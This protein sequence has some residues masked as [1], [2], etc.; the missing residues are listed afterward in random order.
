LRQKKNKL[1]YEEQRVSDIK[2]P[3]HW[4]KRDDQ[5]QLWDYMMRRLLLQLAELKKHGEIKTPGARAVEVAHRQWG[6][7]TLGM[8]FIACAAHLRVGNYWHMLPKSE[9][10]RTAIWTAIN[11]DTGILRIDE[12]F[13]LEIRKQTYQSEMKIILNCGSSYQLVGSDNYNNLV[14]SMPI[15]IWASEWALAN[16]LAWAYLDPMIEKNKGWI[17]FVS[18]SRGRNHLK[19]LYDFA[20]IDDDWFADMKKA[21]E[22]EVFAPEQLKKIERDTIGQFGSD[23]GK[24]IFLQEYECSFEGAVLGSYYSQQMAA[25]RAEK[26]ITVVPW[27]P[28]TEVNTYWDLGLDDSMTIWFIQHIGKSH[29]VIDYEEGTGLGLEWYAKKMKERPY[30]YGNNYMPHDADQREMTNS[31]IALS[32]REVAENLGIKPIIVIPRA[33]NMDVIVNVHIPAVRNILPS[34]WFDEKKCA[35]GINSLENYHAKYDEVKK[36]LT[37]R[38]EHDHNSHGADAFRTFA[39]GYEPAAVKDKSVTEMMRTVRI[40]N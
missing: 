1:G 5:T 29:H 15:G 16:P 4:S 12:A 9:Q 14:S 28:N 11:P 37:R 38:P 20:C 40:L 26:R 22:T 8:H 6:K 27:Q 10:A 3:N 19:T 21:S 36:V 2:L 33:Q 39:V 25:A 24:A 35:L 34:C 17:A 7:D 13:P 18:T 23:M 30:V 32:R 31:E